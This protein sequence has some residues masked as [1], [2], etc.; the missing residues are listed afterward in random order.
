MRVWLDDSLIREVPQ[1][2]VHVMTAHD[3]IELLKQG[4]TE[5]I[6]LDRDL[7]FMDG[8]MYNSL[9][10]APSGEEVVHWMV[11]N[12]CFP[13]IINIHSW[14]IQAAERMRLEFQE[15]GVRVLVYPYSAEISRA[16]GRI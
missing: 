5:I 2:W 1:G 8:Q 3:C 15:A 14:N 7:G 10:E 11:K 6:S 16:L 12:K 4:T 9:A 13:R